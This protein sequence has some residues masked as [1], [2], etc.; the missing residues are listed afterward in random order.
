MLAR[1][2]ISHLQ[3][4]LFKLFAFELYASKTENLS[5]VD[6]MECIPAAGVASLI[7]AIPCRQ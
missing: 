7:R 3:N 5:S 2:L 4:E 6:F 1:Q